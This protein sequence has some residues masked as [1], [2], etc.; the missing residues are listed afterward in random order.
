MNAEE[1]AAVIDDAMNS[2]S[3]YLLE[4][5]YSPGSPGSATNFK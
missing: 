2:R 3:S 5:H 1:K 4:L